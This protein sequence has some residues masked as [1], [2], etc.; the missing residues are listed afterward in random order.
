MSETTVE[1]CVRCANG[2][3]DAYPSES[4]ARQ[5]ARSFDEHDHPCGPHRVIKR[6]KR[7]INEEDVTDA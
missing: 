4:V 1:Y 7:T 5:H 6:I 3:S 2:T